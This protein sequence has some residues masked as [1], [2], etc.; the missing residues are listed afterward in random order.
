MPSSA[1]SA[2]SGTARPGAASAGPRGP[3][4]WAAS[5]AGPRPV[6]RAAPCPRPGPRL[7]ASPAPS[8][9][10]LAA[11]SSGP[12]PRCLAGRGGAGGLLSLCPG[13]KISPEACSCHSVRDVPG[14]GG[15]SAGSN[16][17]RAWAGQGET[18]WTG[19][20]WAGVQEG[21]LRGACWFPSPSPTTLPRKGAG[22]P[23]RWLAQLLVT[24]TPWGCKAPGRSRPSA[25]RRGPCHTERCRT[26]AP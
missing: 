8:P 13:S 19:Q 5:S 14:G 3:A 15:G 1:G 26:C 11:E 23:A 20:G 6:G 10:A 9:W 7:P 2:G 18:G 17:S 4:S 21:G 16:G 22:G 12:S 25:L 24:P